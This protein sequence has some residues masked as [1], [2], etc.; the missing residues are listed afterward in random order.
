MKCVALSQLALV[1]RE[2]ASESHKARLY[3]L[4]RIYLD[5]EKNDEVRLKV[6]DKFWFPFK[7][8]LRVVTIHTVLYFIHSILFI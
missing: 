3:F 5:G 1:T 6:M 2:I 4:R 7:E 8:D